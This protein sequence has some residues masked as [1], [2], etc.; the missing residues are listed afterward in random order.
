MSLVLLL[1]SAAH[2]DRVYWVAPPVPADTDAVARTLPGVKAMP[3]DDLVSTSTGDG[4]AAIDALRAELTAVRPLLAEFDGELKIMARLRKGTADVTRLRS[5]EDA[6]LMRH[7]LLVE[8]NAVHRYFGDRLGL[9]PASLP[10]T[11][12]LGPAL[13]V[14]AWVDAVALDGT[15]NPDEADLPE[16]PQRLS[17]DG[18][19][20]LMNAMPAAS[21]EIGKLASGAEV[22]LDGKKVNAAPGSRTLMVP[23]RHFV[24]VRA[25]GAELLTGDAELAEG[26]TL[27]AEAP[28][29][30]VERDALIA[31]V[32]SADAGWAVSEAAMMPISGA[33]EPVYLALP[34]AGR[35]KLA[36]VDRGT[37][38]MMKLVAP[39]KAKVPPISLHAALGAGWVSTG[40]FFLQNVDAGAPYDAATVNAVAPAVSVDVAYR[41]GLF[42][43]SAGV[44]AQFSV[45]D[46]HELPSG[47]SAV[48][49]F[50]YPHVGVGLP[51]VQAT[52][53]PMLP[54]YLGVGLKGR[55][56]VASDLEVVG[57]VVYG[58]GI[59]VARDAS[60]PVYTPLP[61][62]AA[63]GGVGWR[64]D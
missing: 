1:I 58:A 24:S 39:P 51:W 2:A 16:K 18:V 34:G 9:D 28:F 3:L 17:Y 37:A 49:S 55:V 54:W 11:R 14:A 22:W 53:G 33:K 20:A 64:F 31:L 40:D 47:D 43:T 48:R 35:P 44:S 62:Y 60:Q 29:G 46:F 32:K 52:L 42:A 8:G 27:R 45:G 19:R 36:R 26:A 38:E 4:S 30:P 5:P 6:E 61:L 10:Y 56:A 59:E 50:V 41:R 13:V 21:L 12:T 25:G 63:W 15:A 7:A 23:G 57:N